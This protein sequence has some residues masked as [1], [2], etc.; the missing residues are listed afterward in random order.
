MIAYERMKSGLAGYSFLYGF[1][2]S[3]IH[4]DDPSTSLRYAQGERNVPLVLSV[5]A[6]AAESKRAGMDRHH[7]ESVLYTTLYMS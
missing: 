1:L 3:I 5:A 2:M 6:A 4:L 7:R